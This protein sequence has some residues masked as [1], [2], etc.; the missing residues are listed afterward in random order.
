MTEEEFKSL[1]K[2]DPITILK[3]ELIDVPVQCWIDS[4]AKQGKKTGRLFL[5]LLT[6]DGKSLRIK[7]QPHYEYD[8]TL[9]YLD[10]I[11]NGFVKISIPNMIFFSDLE[12]QMTEME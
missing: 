12:R 8:S 3:S 4:A 5:N 1:K 6:K 7:N 2:G 11:Q 9:L 10:D